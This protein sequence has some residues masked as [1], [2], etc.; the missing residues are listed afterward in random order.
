MKIFN[1]TGKNK[2]GELVRGEIEA[3][4]EM[5]AARLLSTRE[6]TTVSVEE[7]VKRS[8]TLFGK[9]SLKDKVIMM[10]QLATMINAGLPIAQSIK[11]LELQTKKTSV[12]KILASAASDVE[13]GSQLSNAL[14]RFPETFTQLDLTLIAS[15][16]TSGT[17]DKALLRMA[18]QL[19]KEQSLM[20]KIRGA[21]IY[22]IFVLVVVVVV[23]AVMVIYVMPQMEGL[24]TSFGAQLPFLTRMMISI[25][26]FLSKFA[27]YLILI[28]IGLA[29]FTGFAIKRPAGRKVWDNLK[30]HLPIINVLLIKMYMARFSRTLSGLV[31]SGV[32]LLDSLNIVSRAVGN[33]IYEELILAA[34]EKVKA[35]VAL[36]DA[37]R[38]NPEFLPIVSEMISVGEKTGELDSMLS[39][40]A[41]YFEDEVD[42]AVKSIS[43]LIEPVMIVILGGLVAIILMAIML[44]IYQIGKIV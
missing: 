10:R 44:P 14:A 34:S 23:V 2:E 16:E 21:L 35:G 12:K 5:A 9:A 17:L 22:P 36:S 28:G 40:L 41:D 30:I 24:Y 32:P 25:S 39:N 18:D 29:I 3:E 6:I 15:G 7:G 27:P 31:G 8:L 19:E 13:G 20:R 42:V 4:N 26:H 38:D 43:N 1:Y 33:V 37:L 11:T